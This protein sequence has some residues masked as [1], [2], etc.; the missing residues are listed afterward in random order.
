MT[1]RRAQRGDVQERVRGIEWRG[2]SWR[3]KGQA[4]LLSIPCFSVCMIEARPALRRRPCLATSIPNPLSSLQPV[5]RTTRGAA[6]TGV[7]ALEPLQK[8]RDMSGVAEPSR[9]TTRSAARA[10][11]G[12]RGRRDA[13]GDAQER[14]EGRGSPQGRRLARARSKGQR[15]GGPGNDRATRGCKRAGRGKELVGEPGGSVAGRGRSQGVRRA[16]RGGRRL[17]S[18]RSVRSRPLASRVWSLKALGVMWRLSP[19]ASG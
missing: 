6:R 5:C 10:G 7:E 16:A 17:R 8:Q 11:G 3:G 4:Q 14:R 12:R 13:L 2:G 15:L 9:A 18:L 19:V 1:A